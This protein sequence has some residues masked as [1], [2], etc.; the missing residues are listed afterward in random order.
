MRGNGIFAVILE[1]TLYSWPEFAIVR[2]VRIECL[3]TVVLLL[4]E[5]NY[6]RAVL[7]QSVVT[8][9]HRLERRPG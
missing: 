1:L 9:T 5:N 8:F 3:K 7:S 4:H 2:K 6:K